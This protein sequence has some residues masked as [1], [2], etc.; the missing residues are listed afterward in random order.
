MNLAKMTVF[1]AKFFV[2]LSFIFIFVF[3]YFQ[4]EKLQ[5]VFI[6]LSLVSL[7]CFIVG[8]FKGQKTTILNLPIVI[9][10]IL[11]VYFLKSDDE[12]NRSSNFSTVQLI[13]STHLLMILNIENSQFVLLI[14]L[15]IILAA[16]IG[17]IIYE[18]SKS[19]ISIF[20]KELLFLGYQVVSTASF[21]AYIY[22]SQKY[23]RIQNKRPDNKK[24]A[25]F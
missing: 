21:A 25:I 23:I 18:F 22:W 12:Q 19:S 5:I 14:Q 2:F 17:L 13:I 16:Y 20:Y 15:A 6:C 4:N 3:V 7:L 9:N 24:N 10:N 11:V 1:Y 8:F